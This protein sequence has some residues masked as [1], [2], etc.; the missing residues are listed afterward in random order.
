MLKTR[1]LT[2]AGLTVGISLVLL[3]SGHWWFLKAVSMILSILAAYELCRTA[4]YLENKRVTLCLLATAAMLSL[5]SSA[6]I[7]G[8]L[9]TAG[10][11]GGLY[12]MKHIQTM[13]KI[14][15]WLLLL[16]VCMVA[17]SFGLMGSLRGMENGFF[18]LV[19]TILIP[20]ITDIGAYC[21]GRCFGKHKLAPII[22]L[23]KTWEGA[24]GGTLCTIALLLAVSALLEANALIQVHFP[25]LAVYLLTASCIAQFGDLTFSAIKRIAGIKDYGTLLPGHGG[26]LDRFDSLILVIPFTVFV[27][28]Y[29][30]PLFGPI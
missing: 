27:N 6:K 15:G 8:L 1:I 19:M 25:Y 18:L 10:L 29:V 9:F 5:C 24:V 12:L 16:A 2:G 17:L 13:E 4:G 11:I 20:V 23:R 30:G 28:L 3:L 7:A 21:F 22:S 14:P 26:I